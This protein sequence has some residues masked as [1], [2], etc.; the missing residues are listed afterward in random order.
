M[1]LD[2]GESASTV[3]SR[4]T[5]NLLG[6]ALISRP[7][8]LG[9]GRSAK[10]LYVNPASFPAIFGADLPR[11]PTRFLAISQRPIAASAFD[12]GVTAAAWKTIPSS[13]VFGSQDRAIDPAELMFLARRAG[14]PVT[15]VKGS[16]LSLI[17]HAE[18]VARVIER[19]AR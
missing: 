11:A 17:S 6:R 7:F 1:A 2:V 13:F 8:P 12:D 10:D 9:G 3:G 5:N 19:A 15:V 14:G 18:T 16:H 4:F